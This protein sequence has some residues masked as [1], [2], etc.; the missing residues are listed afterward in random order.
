MVLI[1]GG[2]Y[3]PFV[4]QKA[5]K[6]TL[7]NEGKQSAISIK[8]FLFDLYPVTNLDFLKFFFK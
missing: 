4:I 7:K 2:Q 5:D 3:V 1:P 6:L 8:Q